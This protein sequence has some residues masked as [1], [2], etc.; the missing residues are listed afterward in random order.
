MS[1]RSLDRFTRGID[2]FNAR[3]GDISNWLYPILMMVIIVN[4]VSR[5]GFNRGFIEFEEIQWHLYS[6]AFLMGMAW[7]YGRNEHVRVDILHANFTPRRKA[8]VE[9]LGCLILLL[10]FTMSVLWYSVP[11]FFNSLALN[12]RSEM[13]SGL[14]ARY[15]IKGFL[16]FGLLLLTLQGISVAI[17]N[18]LFL[19]GYKRD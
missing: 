6:A 16:A 8:W 9:L 15:V 14:P 7:T 10:P 17:Q 4:V 1:L 13:P 11:Y 12:E 3:V 19:A 18:A 2:A 5:Y